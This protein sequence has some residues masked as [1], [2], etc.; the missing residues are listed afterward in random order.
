MVYVVVTSLG[1]L[2]LRSKTAKDPAA[3]RNRF[4]P[5][6]RGSAAR[7]LAANRSASGK[8]ISRE[9]P[10]NVHESEENL[11]DKTSSLSDSR[12]SRLICCSLRL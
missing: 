7:W 3:S 10:P 5:V 2:S 6:A 4:A 8:E 9:F 11:R 12:D 1:F